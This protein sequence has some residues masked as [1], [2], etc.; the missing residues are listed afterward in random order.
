MNWKRRLALLEQR[1]GAV[2]HVQA[3]ALD[4]PER[5]DCV[6]LDSQWQVC[7]DGRAL[8]TSLRGQ[9]VKVYLGLHP[10]DV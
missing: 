1:Q 9:P 2:A 4:V 3:V 8:L 5:G 10:G 6:L 7:A